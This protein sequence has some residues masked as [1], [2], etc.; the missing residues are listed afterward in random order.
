MGGGACGRGL[1][2]FVVS[3]LRMGRLCTLDE[4]GCELSVQEG[5]GAVVGL[6]RSP[7]GVG[8]AQVLWVRMGGASLG[9]TLGSQN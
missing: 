2:G 3:H 7:G 5:A 9:G 6:D 4:A 8:E 1:Q